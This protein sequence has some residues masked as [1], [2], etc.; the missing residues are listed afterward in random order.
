MCSI[1]KHIQKVQIYYNGEN[2]IF[3]TFSVDIRHRFETFGTDF[4]YRVVDRNQS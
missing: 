3:V 2:R 4:E 1:K